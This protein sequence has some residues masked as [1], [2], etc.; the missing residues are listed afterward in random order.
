MDKTV[1]NNENVISIH[2]FANIIDNLP[3]G[4]QVLDKDLRYLFANKAVAEQG[5]T[6]VHNLIGKTITE[7][8][9]G[10]EKSQLLNEISICL[11]NK[12]SKELDNEYVFPDKSKGWF[13]L[14]IVPIPIGLVIFS[15]DIT[16][17]RKSDDVIKSRNND[18]EELNKSLQVSKETNELEKLR[19]EAML[20]SLGEGVFAVDKDNKFIL[21]NKKA[22]EILDLKAKDLIGTGKT[23]GDI[24][25]EDKNGE[26]ISRDK[27]PTKTAI[28]T[29]KGLENK[30]F[31]IVRKDGGRVHISLIVTPIIVEGK[32]IGAIDVFRDIT[33]EEEIDK[34]KSEFVSL[35]SHQLRTPLGIEKWYLEAIEENG[36]LKNANSN[37]KTYIDEI[38]KNNKRLLSLV[39]DLLSVSRIEQGNVRNEPKRINILDL[40]RN[41]VKE[42]KIM[43]IN[44]KVDINL[45]IKGK[46]PLT[47]ID[48]SR[49]EEVIE[50]LVINA[51]KYNIENGKV[52]IAVEN[53][54]NDIIISVKDT[55]IGISDSDMPKIFTKFYRAEKAVINNPEGSGLGLYLAKSY[56]EAWGGKIS[57]E[58]VEDK[59]SIFALTIP[60][61]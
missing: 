48:P 14:K 50:N 41:I 16:S 17:V 36:Y 3:E 11:K 12:T 55:G 10:I 49:A 31:V 51:I 1:Q 9:P 57:V 54:K 7:V 58:S 56:A 28:T 25:L 53:R 19:A 44:K 18:L 43:A 15:N 8:F 26:P 33:K 4:C 42:M 5:Q 6:T 34:A 59:G 2:D 60:T 29:G 46:I 47:L 35:A 24:P 37:A 61:K 32:I 30:E 45:K 39:N 52:D 21:L 22:E 27:R 20:D 40:I 23:P 38:S 13:K